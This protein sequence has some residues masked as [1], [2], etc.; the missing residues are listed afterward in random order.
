MTWDGA[1]IEGHDHGRLLRF[2][3]FWVIGRGSEMKDCL[4]RTI[5]KAHNEAVMSRTKT[6]ANGP[7]FSYFTTSGGRLETS[8]YHYQTLITEPVFS[9]LMLMD[10]RQRW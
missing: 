2:W 10:K 5:Q 4:A 1:H 9:Q 8:G 6:L 3:W 7:A